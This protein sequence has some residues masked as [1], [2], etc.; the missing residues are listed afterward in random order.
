MNVFI[1][2]QNRL[3]R[4]GCSKVP[5]EDKGARAE[6]EGSTNPE[7]DKRRYI[8]KGRC[9]SDGSELLPGEMEFECP[10]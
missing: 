1:V 9:A 2:A 4:N 10:R 6:V 3:R 5:E 8:G 7:G